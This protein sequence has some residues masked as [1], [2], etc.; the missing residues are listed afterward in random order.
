[1]QSFRSLAFSSERIESILATL[2]IFVVNWL[3]RLWKTK[4][5][6][7]INPPPLEKASSSC[8]IIIVISQYLLNYNERSAGPEFEKT[9][10][11]Y[12][13]DLNHY[14]VRLMILWFTWCHFSSVCLIFVSL[15]EH[16][17]LGADCPKKSTEQFFLCRYF[18]VYLVFLVN[19]WMLLSNTFLWP[20]FILLYEVVRSIF[21]SIDE[22]PKFDHSNESLWS[23]LSWVPFDPV[24]YVV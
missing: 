6:F 20:Q 23:V 16:L 17:N 19:D 2:A 5:S 10:L 3:Y 13:S 21:K 18:M 4:V 15:V 9:I 22:I 1:M 7:E 24:Y 11:S 8:L 14:L 12:V